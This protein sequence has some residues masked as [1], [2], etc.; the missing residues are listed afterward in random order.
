MACNSEPQVVCRP[1]KACALSDLVHVCLWRDSL[2]D[3]MIRSLRFSI[4]GVNLNAD[5][6]HRVFAPG[7]CKVLS[8]ACTVESRSLCF[9]WA[10]DQAQP[11]VSDMDVFSQRLNAIVHV[12]IWPVSC[13]P[14]RVLKS[15]NP[16]TAWKPYQRPAH[17]P[18]PPHERASCIPRPKSSGLS[19]PETL[20]ACADTAAIVS[21]NRLD[22]RVLAIVRKPLELWTFSSRNSGLRV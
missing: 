17:S 16:K 21:A 15:L 1:R 12:R 4:S 14:C 19:K 8:E 11:A 3:S 2:P 10:Q 18:V 20:S 7:I 6:S 22:P 13:G 9:L 5:S